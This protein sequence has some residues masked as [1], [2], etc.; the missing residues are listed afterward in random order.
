[1]EKRVV[2]VFLTY[3]NEIFTFSVYDFTEV[4]NFNFFNLSKR[5]RY[6]NRAPR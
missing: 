5:K 3:S 6:K 2:P 4:D 1:M